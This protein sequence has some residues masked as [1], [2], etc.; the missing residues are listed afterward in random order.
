M[1]RVLVLLF[2]W[3]GCSLVGS[4][5]AVASPQSKD[6]KAYTGKLPKL[7]STQLALSALASQDAKK[8]AS[9]DKDQVDACKDSMCQVVYGVRPGRRVFGFLLNLIPLIALG[10]WIIGDRLGSYLGMGLQI[11][12]LALVIVSAVTYALSSIADLLFVLGTSI[13]SVGYIIPLITVWV[14]NR[15][16]RFRRRRRYY[17]RRRRYRREYY[18]GSPAQVGTLDHAMQFRSFGNNAT[19][20][21]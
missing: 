3:M 18:K 2:V 13:M 6:Q 8:I 11:T 1:S 19:F 17:R 9:A 10:S 4:A 12:G 15:G 14:F 5:W 21:F 7:I 16:P 20:A